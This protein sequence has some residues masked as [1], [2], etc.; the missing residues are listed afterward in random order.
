[1]SLYCIKSVYFQLLDKIIERCLN[2]IDN[3]QFHSTSCIA[4]TALGTGVFRYSPK[5]VARCMYKTSVRWANANQNSHLKEIRFV[6]RHENVIKV[7][8][9]CEFARTMSHYTC[10][11]CLYVI[12]HVIELAQL[13]YNTMLSTFASCFT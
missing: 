10:I 1:M 9:F 5:H 2:K 8:R 3:A 12:S 7:H 13:Q 6:L 11:V 4:F